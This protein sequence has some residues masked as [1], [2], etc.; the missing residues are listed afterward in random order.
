MILSLSAAVALIIAAGGIGYGLG[1]RGTPRELEELRRH[2]ENC[3]ED[4]YLDLYEEALADAEHW[5]SAIVRNAEA[6][7]VG[8]RVLARRVS[9][10]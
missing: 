1:V 4:H 10:P 2:L 6:I 8:R 5:R 7:R 3:D 9:L